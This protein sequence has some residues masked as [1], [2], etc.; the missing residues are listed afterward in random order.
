[1]RSTWGFS[2]GEGGNGIYT[3]TLR[4]KS[5]DKWDKLLKDGVDMPH[6]MQKWTEMEALIEEKENQYKIE[7]GLILDN[8][9][10]DVDDEDIYLKKESKTKKRR[11]DKIKISSFK[12]EIPVL[13]GIRLD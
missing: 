2:T 12:N 9:D 5:I 8:D 1:L 11:R 6:N 10:D 7:N 4:K 13:E 3:A